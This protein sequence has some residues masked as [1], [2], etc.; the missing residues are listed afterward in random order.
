MV[1]EQSDPMGDRL[2]ESTKAIENF[3]KSIQIDPPR[4]TRDMA[5]FL[6]PILQK[7]H[8]LLVILDDRLAKLEQ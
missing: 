6:I 5:Q 2:D 3:V 8:D 7:Q 1:T 4:T